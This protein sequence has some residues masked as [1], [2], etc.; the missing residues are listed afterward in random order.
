[1]KIY[2]FSSF[3]NEQLIADLKV[4][5]NSFWVDEFHFTESNRDFNFNPKSFNYKISSDQVKHYM[6]DGS[7]HFNRTHL[8]LSK[9]KWFVKSV[10]VDPWENDKRQRNYCVSSFL[11]ADDDIVILSDIDE[12]LDSRLSSELI[13]STLNHGIIT[14]KLHYTLYYFNLYS[15]HWAGPPDYSYRVFLMTGK[16]F[17]ERKINS[18]N[19]RKAG[20]RGD[21]VDSVYCYPEFAGFHHSWL[22]DESKAMEKLRAYPHAQFEH[23]PNIYTEEGDFIKDE[24][25]KLITSGLSIYGS[26]HK[27]EVRNDINLLTSV[28][29]RKSNDLSKFFL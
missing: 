1:M 10:K 28:M 2:E 27:L 23:D 17:N 20:E 8:K 3:Y 12:I 19:L 29:R 9:S 6:M 7:K 22:G 18:D 5:E 11:P 14:V 15:K 4:E 13:E 16:Y 24:V 26:D 21:L 25:N